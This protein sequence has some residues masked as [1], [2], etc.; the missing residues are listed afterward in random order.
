MRSKIFSLLHEGFKQEIDFAYKS[1]TLVVLHMPDMH[2]VQQ[3]KDFIIQNV[4]KI[5][6][7]RKRFEDIISQD[8]DLEQN[9][10]KTADRINL[11]RR[12]FEEYSKSITVSFITILTLDK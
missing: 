6:I 10:E 1:S 5:N 2:T 7:A 12:L 4:N 11:G 8:V 3:L 9:V